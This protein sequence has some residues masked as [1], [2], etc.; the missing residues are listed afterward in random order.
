MEKKT[1]IIQTNTTKKGKLDQR[2][3]TCQL[4][5]DGENR[6]YVLDDTKSDLTNKHFTLTRGCRI[7]DDG[8]TYLIRD[9]SYLS[10]PAHPYITIYPNITI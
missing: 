3:F 1:V 10:R 4:H 7:T 9:V 6:L 5:V 8:V 2:S